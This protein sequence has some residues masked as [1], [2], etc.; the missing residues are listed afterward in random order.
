MSLI[1][2]DEKVN[3]SREIARRAVAAFN[4]KRQ[5][6]ELERRAKLRSLEQSLERDAF[7]IRA[8]ERVTPCK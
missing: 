5:N 7:L 2:V 3:Q 8:L 4:E 1:I 6:K